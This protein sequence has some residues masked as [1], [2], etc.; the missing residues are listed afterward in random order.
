[1][2]R[3]E[4]ALSTR[5]DFL[6]RTETVVRADSPHGRALLLVNVRHLRDINVA[7]GSARTDRVLQQLNDCF[8]AQLR[9]GDLSAHLGGD[10]YGV[11]LTQLPN[12][13]VALLAAAKLHNAVKPALTVDSDEVPIRLTIGIAIAQAG[14][15]AESLLR[16]ANIAVA[17]ARRTERES[18]L[19]SEDLRAGN[20]D[21]L[22][23]RKELREA[24]DNGELQ[25]H[26]QPK[27]DLATGAVRGAEALM[28]WPSPARGWV[29]P[30]VFIAIA[31]QSDLIEPL[32]FW[33]INTALR[34]CSLCR[35]KLECAS[36]AV[37][38]SA[39]ILHHPHLVEIVARAMN[40]WGTQPGNLILEVT[41]S[42][43]MRDPAASLRTLQ[44]LHDQ[45]ITISIDDFGTGYSSLA[46]L[47]KLPIRELKI[48]K[49]FVI[50]M[51]ND[52]DDESIVRAIVD[53]SHTLG[54]AVVAEGIE[55]AD[56]LDRLARMGCDYGQGY[57]IA[58]PMPAD[59]MLDWVAARDALA[60]L[61]GCR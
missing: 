55:N 16:K 14:D 33:S 3:T 26:Y 32:S 43:M 46:Y 49:S 9:T 34:Q 25:L 11:L 60:P 20:Q 61:S 15:S 1:M 23:L 56:T 21:W 59:A 38:L 35:S 13:S 37:N 8:A 40:I 44:T 50:N 7:L 51:H 5:T 58:R 27:I 30:D 52:R 2:H 47:K 48:D 19:Y 10:E 6:L 22:S 29:P 54:V 12:P 17:D 39:N 41:E 36:V 28:R 4:G 31:E 53:L 18:V 24:I 45:G 57:F 42:A